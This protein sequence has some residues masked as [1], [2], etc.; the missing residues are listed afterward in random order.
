[1]AFESELFKGVI[2]C[3]F[4][5]IACPANRAAART[6]ED[7]FKKKRCTFQVLV[8]GK[9]KE[10]I[11]ADLVLTGGEFHTSRSRSARRITVSAGCK[12]FAAL[13][14]GLELDLLC[15][16]PF[17]TAT[18][19]GTVTTLSVDAEETR[20]IRSRTFVNATAEWVERFLD[21]RRRLLLFRTDT[22]L[23]AT[24]RF[25]LERKRERTTAG[26][27]ED[28]MKETRSSPSSPVS[29]AELLGRQ[30]FSRAAVSRAGR[31]EHG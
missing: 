14:P 5:G 7:F 11:R 26:G 2:V 31:P 29:F 22:L 20:P 12:F 6:K 25:R 28:E 16:E 18:L 9:F 8:Q 13:T 17:Y 21:E 23:R 1:M 19:G 30:R 3:R 24:V 15:D 4:K 10:R 27:E